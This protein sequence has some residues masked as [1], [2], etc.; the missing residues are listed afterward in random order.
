MSSQYAALSCVWSDIGVVHFVASGLQ[1]G[2]W[3]VK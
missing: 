3:V 2:V 1:R